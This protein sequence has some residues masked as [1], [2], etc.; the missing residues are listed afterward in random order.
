MCRCEI[1]NI[2]ACFIEEPA[3]EV[4]AN[5][6]LKHAKM[7]LSFPNSNHVYGPLHKKGDELCKFN[8]INIVKFLINN[9]YD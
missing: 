4:L 9:I 5:L 7:H 8:V 1:W 2:K 6:N 3:L